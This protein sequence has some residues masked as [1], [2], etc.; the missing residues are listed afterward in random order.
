MRQKKKKTCRGIREFGPS[1]PAGSKD[2]RRGPRPD[3]GEVL[4]RAVSSERPFEIL[5]FLGMMT[6]YKSDAR[7]E[8][9]FSS[10]ETSPAARRLRCTRPRAAGLSSD[11]KVEVGNRFPFKTRMKKGGLRT[12]FLSGKGP[13]G[14][15]AGKDWLCESSLRREFGKGNLGTLVDARLS[16]QQPLDDVFGRTDDCAGVVD[17]KAPIVDVVAVDSRLPG[18]T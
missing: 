11:P 2:E 17:L 14:H 13:P 6:Q 8:S 15:G 7:N 18:P 16:R 1:N 4:F 12:A 9:D 3:S 10:R 5:R